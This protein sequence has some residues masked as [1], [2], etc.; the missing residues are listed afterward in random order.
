MGA[1]V[2]THLLGQEL[3]ALEEKIKLYRRARR[4]AGHEGEGCVTIALHTFVGED[5]EAVKAKVK[6][7]M[8]RYLADSADLMKSLSQA[9]Y[10]GCEMK[11]L[12][13]RKRVGSSST[14]STGISNSAGCWARRRPAVGRCASLRRSASTRSHA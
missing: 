3:P 10:P 13:R 9:M 8:I 12:T 1:G 11:N 6:E 7:P 14:L 4:E 2:L 5:L